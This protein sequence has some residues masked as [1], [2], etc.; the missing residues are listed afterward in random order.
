[1]KNLKNKKGG[2]ALRNSKGFTLIEI[3]VVLGIIAILAAIVIVA[4]N[5]KKHF[6]DALAS[7]RSAGANSI[8]NAIGQYIVGEKGDLTNLSLPAVPVDP[9]DPPTPITNDQNGL[10]GDLIPKYSGTLPTDPDSTLEGAA[11]TACVV[12]GSTSIGYTIKQP[13]AGQIV[14]CSAF[15]TSVCAAI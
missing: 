6:D 3:L 8:M 4:V 15:D 9:T 11:L 1:M 7:T 5:P 2:L 13:T 14:V 10:C 12:G